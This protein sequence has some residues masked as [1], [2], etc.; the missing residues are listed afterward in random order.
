MFIVPITATAINN[1]ND[2]FKY[3][4]FARIR[5][6]TDITYTQLAQTSAQSTATKEVSIH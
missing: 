4:L 1:D 6:E 2:K 3:I 5:G